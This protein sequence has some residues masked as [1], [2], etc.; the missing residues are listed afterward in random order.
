[1]KL[2]LA[3]GAGERV[4][5]CIDCGQ[6]DPLQNAE[7]PSWLKGELGSKKVSDNRL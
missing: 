3:K 4:L 1:M 5:R 6:P 7:T 2:M